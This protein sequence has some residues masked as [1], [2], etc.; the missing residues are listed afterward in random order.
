MLPRRKVGDLVAKVNG[1]D[2]CTVVIEAKWDKRV[3]DGDP[4]HLDE[5]GNITKNAEKTAYGQN[6]TSVI[7]READ[8]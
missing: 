7:N 2:D 8:I 6:L 1:A 4:T 3:T 5:S